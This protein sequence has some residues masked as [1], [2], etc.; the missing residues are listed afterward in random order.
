[1][2]YFKITAL[3]VAGL[4]AGAILFL[5]AA[6]RLS[7]PAPPDTATMIA[8]SHQYNVHIERDNFGVPHVIG[9]RDADVAFGF[10][11]AHCEDDFDTIQKVA[12]AMRGQLAAMEGRSAAVS[13][14]LVH[15]FRIWETVN[16][17]YQSDLPADVRQVLEAYAD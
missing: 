11:F 13:D 4:L 14:Y 9:L 8:K 15:F 2:R 5:I 12:L 10:G 6:D 17:R 7:Q 1:M 16:A 3:T